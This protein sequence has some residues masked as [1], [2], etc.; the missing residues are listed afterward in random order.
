MMTG[1]DHISDAGSTPATSTTLMGVPR[2]R[3]DVLRVR[4]SIGRRLPY[5][6][7]KGLCELA[8]SVVNSANQI[9]A[10]SN[11]FVMPSKAARAFALAA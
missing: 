6:C 2:F 3:R 1:L 8:F 4:E 10:K 5:D 11:L 7:P 9:T